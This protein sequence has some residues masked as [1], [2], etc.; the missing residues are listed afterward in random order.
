M[1][2]KKKG[3]DGKWEYTVAPA[4]V[5]GLLAPLRAHLE[6]EVTRSLAMDMIDLTARQTAAQP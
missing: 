2:T 3:N 1:K 6:Q 4:N 5:W